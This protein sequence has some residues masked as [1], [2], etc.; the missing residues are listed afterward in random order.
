VKDLPQPAQVGRDGGGWRSMPVERG[1]SGD[2]VQ[3]FEFRRQTEE[4]REYLTPHTRSFSH[5]TAYTDLHPNSNT[6]FPTMSQLSGKAMSYWSKRQQ[7]AA[8][9]S[10]LQEQGPRGQYE[11]HHYTTSS[12]L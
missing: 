7:T 11:S 5:S 6:L 4:N 1:T 9:D 3:Y 2:A 12:F 8:I 10:V